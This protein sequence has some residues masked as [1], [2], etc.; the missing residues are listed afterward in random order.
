MSDK[1]GASEWPSLAYFFNR[2]G[3]GAASTGAAQAGVAIGAARCHLAS[4]SGTTSGLFVEKGVIIS[5]LRGQK[6][7]SG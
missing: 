4:C 3:A 6:W 2:K 1:R 5:L 7:P